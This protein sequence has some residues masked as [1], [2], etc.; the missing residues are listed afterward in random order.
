MEHLTLDSFREG[1]FWFFGLIGLIIYKVL[2]YLMPQ[3][4][5]AFF[6]HIKLKFT[7]DLS[8]SVSDLTKEVSLYK[9]HKH[10]IDNENF[11]LKQ[12]ILSDD[13]ELL[14]ELKIILKKEKNGK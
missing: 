3:A 10:C 9:N 13:K 6:N 1:I 14:E 8:K 12:A 5:E 7:A 11:A 2:A 4:Y